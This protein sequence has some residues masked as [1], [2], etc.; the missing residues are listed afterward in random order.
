MPRIIAWLLHH[1]RYRDRVLLG[2]TLERIHPH[3]VPIL[4]GKPR[5]RRPRH[6]HID[7]YP[8]RRLRAA[9]IR[10]QNA[11]DLH[12]LERGVRPKSARRPDHVGERL[13]RLGLIDCGPQHRA[14]HPHA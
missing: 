7:R 4:E 2:G 11:L 6:R 9:R 8:R 13:A 3:D 10:G 1:P 5:Q 12:A 14:A